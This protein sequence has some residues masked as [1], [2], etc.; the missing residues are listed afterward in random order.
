MN[1]RRL[2]LL[3][4]CL[5]GSGY[6][7]AVDIMP[8]Q[9]VVL[10]TG[11]SGAAIAAT[12]AAIRGFM[13]DGGYG[14]VFTFAATLGFMVLMIKLAMRTEQFEKFPAYLIGLFLII[15]VSQRITINVQVEDPVKGYA[16]VVSDVPAIVGGPAVVASELGHWLTAAIEHYYRV[17]ASLPSGVAIPDN[18]GTLTETNRFNLMGTMMKDLSEIRIN[19]PGM[20]GSFRAYVADCAAPQ[21]YT[22]QINFQ[23]LVSSN[24]P[25]GV[26]TATPN[27]Y[28]FTTY[29]GPS[30]TISTAGGSTAVDPLGSVV[31]C[32]ESAEQLSDDLDDFVYPSA[33]EGIAR[34]QS[35]LGNFEVLSWTEGALNSAMAWTSNGAINTASTAVRQT[36]VI[37]TF[38]DTSSSIMNSVAGGE[39]IAYNMALAEARSAQE[40]NWA[41]A[42][43][44]F[45][46]FM[47]YF[48]VVLHVFVIALSPVI[49]L[50]LLIPGMAGKIGGSYM[51][52]L[53]WLALWQPALSVVNF[54]A[55]QFLL[56]GLGEPYIIPGGGFTLGSVTTVS[57]ATEKAVM[58]ANFMGSMVPMFMWGVINA[59]G[60][61]FT[62][63]VGA[64]TGASQAAGAAG[65]VASDSINHGTHSMDVTRANKFDMAYDTSIGDN[66]VKSTNAVGQ[67]GADLMTGTTRTGMSGGGALGNVSTEKR[68]AVSSESSRQSSATTTDKSADSN[69][70][71]NTHSSGVSGA[72]TRA[73]QEQV[74]A[75]LQQ[76]SSGTRVRQG[77]ELDQS[78]QTWSANYGSKFQ[79]GAS[80]TNR[81]TETFG[82]G[83]D[84][85]KALRALT[86]TLDQAGASPQQ[87][88][89]S[90]TA[91]ATHA[92]DNP[93]FSGMTKAEKGQ[94][95]EAAVNNALVAD[96][97]ESASEIAPLNTPEGQAA[98]DKHLAKNGV[99]SVVDG[100]G[101]KH[102]VKGKGALSKIVG[103]TPHKRLL[104]ALLGGAT[105]R[106]DKG[107]QA[108]SS[109]DAGS[110][111]E[112]GA[113]RTDGNSNSFTFGDQSAYTT[114]GTRNNSA[115]GTAAE[116][117]TLTQT[118]GRNVSS[119]DSNTAE[120]ANTSA[121]SAQT[122]KSVTQS[123]ER[124]RPDIAGGVRGR[125][126]WDNEV[127]A[128]A[129]AVAAQMAALQSKTTKGMEET[130][131]ESASVV[132]D[133]NTRIAD[134]E[135]QV[136]GE[137][138][139]S[140]TTQGKNVDSGAAVTQGSNLSTDPITA[141]QAEV[142]RAQ[143]RLAIAQSNG[144]NTAQ[145]TLLDAEAQTA[146]GAQLAKVGSATVVEQQRDGADLKADSTENPGLLR[147]AMQYAQM[148]QNS[149]MSLVGTAAE[150]FV[151]EAN[152]GVIGDIYERIQDGGALAPSL[153]MQ[154]GGQANLRDFAVVGE[155]SDAR[156]RGVYQ[157]PFEY[158]NDAGANVQGMAA[159][160]YVQDGQFFPL[161]GAS[162]EESRS[163]TTEQLSQMGGQFVSGAT[164]D[165]N[166]LRIGGREFDGS[167]TNSGAN[168]PVGQGQSFDR[169]M[170]N[171]DG[172]GQVNGGPNP[173]SSTTGGAV[174]DAGTVNIQQPAGPV[175]DPVQAGA[176]LDGYHA[177]RGD[178]NSGVDSAIAGERTTFPQQGDSQLVDDIA[179]M[180]AYGTP[181]YR[182][183]M[184]SDFGSSVQI[185]LRRDEE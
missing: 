30:P 173:L 126:G 162:M 54:I 43:D 12:L 105:L 122:R 67:W 55:N 29:Y 97:L 168:I 68:E 103:N 165:G 125:Q 109:F 49:I 180:P 145:N 78:I 22:G 102:S 76:S 8:G 116:G 88:Q 93:N 160:V 164:M 89:D 137:G 174:Q 175:A 23:T 6:A 146:Y 167:T 11:G 7:S 32:R 19:D 57:A 86:G 163:F 135:K 47:G 10:W 79:M 82:V 166:T 140:G 138:A 18:Y 72:G 70:V 157:V 156:L 26:L 5:F 74:Q 75:S 1:A 15:Y 119:A 53:I 94:A 37:N 139:V 136:P 121:Q 84:L 83:A 120:T 51:K 184:D 42:A 100:N 99:D 65:K 91:A 41:I 150:A 170:I 73:A 118:E 20:R 60:Y 71:A 24:D 131:A 134:R 81:N 33:V 178:H 31:T 117:D 62:Q 39:G 169:G 147:S 44:I 13:N 113:G 181:E 64:G 2:L 52:I 141:A 106:W 144:A 50:L 183:M 114:G 107:Q 36:A 124:L 9:A 14:T 132:S 34:K 159:G 77:S 143:G 17:P 182:K 3:F 56:D 92:L 123:Q 104:D 171:E 45:S 177:S 90:L 154:G 151:P 158:T 66:G 58:A 172:D 176:S 161:G 129:A 87:K 153:A 108:I 128:Q 142:E 27:N 25:W 16:S 179:D 85:G 130:K 80:E 149:I 95:V 69:V 28:T 40:S 148:G 35:F 63:F 4:V 155:G 38:I 96:A 133:T 110:S 21:L 101:N 48:Y 112:R 59:T 152:G 98:A 111:V 127:D 46:T 61:A 115:T 185:P